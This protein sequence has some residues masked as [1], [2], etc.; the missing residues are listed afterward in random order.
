MTRHI[1]IKLTK[2]MLLLTEAE[3]VKLL[4]GD[5]ALWQAAIKRGKAERRGRSMAARGCQVKTN[6]LK[7]GGTVTM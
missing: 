3:L 2:C 7:G 1:E 4:A 6:Q 5:P